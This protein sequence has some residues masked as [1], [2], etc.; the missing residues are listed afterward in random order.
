MALPIHLVFHSVADGI[1]RELRT[2]VRLIDPIGKKSI[3]LKN[4]IWDTGATGTVIRED[5]ATKL[6]LVAIGLTRANTAHGSADVNTYAV[7]LDLPPLDNPKVRIRGITACEMTLDPNTEIL[8]GMD[9]ISIGD[10]IVENDHGKTTF[11]F[12][13]PPFD[14]KYDMLGK[15]DGVN[16]RNAK[17]NAR[18]SRGPLG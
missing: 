9:V 13:L 1:A 10:F 17:K 8:V 18:A 11:S 16:K 4:A 12:C 2:P 5:V 14:N 6:G 7:E 3:E 15:A